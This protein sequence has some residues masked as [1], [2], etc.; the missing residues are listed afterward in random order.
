MFIVEDATQ[1]ARFHD[2]PLVVGD[3]YIRFYAGYPLSGANGLRL[4]TLCIID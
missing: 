4:G 3:P 1:D 2:N